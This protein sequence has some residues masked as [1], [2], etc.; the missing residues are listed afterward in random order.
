MKK[1]GLLLLILALILCFA[2]CDFIEGKL[3]DYLNQ[4]DEQ[5]N[6]TSTPADTDGKAEDFVCGEVCSFGRG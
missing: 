2:S 3:R 1:L 4:L 6:E 5:K